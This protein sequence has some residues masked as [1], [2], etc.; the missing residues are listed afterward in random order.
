MKSNILTLFLATSLFANN[1]AD[2]RRC[3]KPIPWP[4][5]TNESNYNITSFGE[6]IEWR[7]SAPNLFYGR[8]GVGLTNAS[9]AAEAIV[10]DP[11]TSYYPNFQYDPGFK[12]GVGVQF[13]PKKMFDL[14]ANYTWLYSVSQGSVS[15]QNI[16]ASFLP[17]NFLTS[18]TLASN[19]YSFASM[20]LN[21]HFNWLELQAGYTLRPVKYL[22]FRPYMSLQGTI[23]EGA[24]RVRYEYTL[25]ATSGGASSGTFEIAK[26]TGHSS[27]WSIGPRLGLDF[28]IQA[29]PNFAIYYNASWTQ[30]AS[31]IQI[32][33][34][35]T[36]TR[37]AS[38]VDF[39]IQK[40]ALV[41]DRNVGIYSLELGPVWDIW[42]ADN[43]Y[44]LQLR[45]TWTAT[46]M[47]AGALISFLNNNN[48]DIIL[49][50]ELR[51]VNVRATFEF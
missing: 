38:N 20:G 5:V 45:A 3:V 50:S 36:Q 28:T 37:P 24:L 22:I 7:Y 44:H 19:R 41:A 25:T 9:P 48:A 46:N 1:P 13:G 10:D 29:T 34:K 6:F 2:H 16:S 18:S 43:K 15:G 39:V 12:L 49:A 32:N 35:Q 33:T 31:H 17:L 47:A 51:G 8:D 30:Q 42:F 4:K 23:I 26:T 40:G 14:I 11:G 21:V 27:A